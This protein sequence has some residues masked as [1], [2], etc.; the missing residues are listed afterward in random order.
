MYGTAKPYVLRAVFPTF[1]VLPV[2][3]SYSV[4]YMEGGKTRGYYLFAIV[5]AIVNKAIEQNE[6][7]SK[8]FFFCI[9]ML[10]A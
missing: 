2:S 3:A 5:L 8:R 9:R 7:T 1:F 4:L 6:R 10:I